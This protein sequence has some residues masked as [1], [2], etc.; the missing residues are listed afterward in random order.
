MSNEAIMTFRDICHIQRAL[1][2][3][4]KAIMQDHLNT[5]CVVDDTSDSSSRNSHNR[6]RMNW[7]SPFLKWLLFCRRQHFKR[8]ASLERVFE[9][10]SRW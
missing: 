9:G 3:D 7:G 1:G 8:A 2:V 10:R 6:S 5:P 4:T